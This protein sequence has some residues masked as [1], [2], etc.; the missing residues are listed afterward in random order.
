[1]FMQIQLCVKITINLVFRNNDSELLMIQEAKQ[2]SRGMWFLPA[3]KGKEGE[4]ITDTCIRETTEESGVTTKPIYLL[5]TEHIIR[6]IH[7][8]KDDERKPVDI[9]RFIF[10]SQALDNNLKT[11]E[12]K[13]S[14]QAKWIP[15]EEVK[16]L[17]LR[18]IEVLNYIESYQQQKKRNSLAQLDDILDVYND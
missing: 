15:V 4:L 14:I 18:S 12:T 11:V 7:L 9:F 5:R 8:D 10:V 17:P 13:D 16:N 1:M 2:H 3:G 6:N